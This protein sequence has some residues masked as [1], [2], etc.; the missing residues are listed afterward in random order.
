MGKR[1]LQRSGSTARSSRTARRAV[2]RISRV[3]ICRGV[4]LKYVTC[5]Q[6]RAKYVRELGDL[7]SERD[8]THAEQTLG[9]ELAGLER[10]AEYQGQDLTAT[11]ARV[12]KLNAEIAALQKVRRCCKTPPKSLPALTALFGAEVSPSRADRLQNRR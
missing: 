12:S 9:G 2:S 4:C 11:H 3:S 7:P 5:T 6:E 1:T 10:Q 8:S